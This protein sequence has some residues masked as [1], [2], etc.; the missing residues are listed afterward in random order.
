VARALSNK[1]RW[2]RYK[3]RQKRTT[4]FLEGRIERGEPHQFHRL[5]ARMAR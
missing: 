1:E 4:D 2:A 5:L 3:L